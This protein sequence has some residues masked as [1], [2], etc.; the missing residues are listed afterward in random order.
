[1]EASAV[2]ARLI[3][4]IFV[5]KGLISDADLELALQEQEKTGLRLGEILVSSF[6]VSRL[7]L[8]G[9]LAEQW[10]AI[11]RASAHDRL[12]PTRTAAETDAGDMAAIE[13]EWRRPDEEIAPVEERR[14]IGEIFV[15]KGVIT[16]EQLQRALDEQRQTGA[17]LGEVLVAQETL[18]RLELA[19]ALAEQWSDLQKLR[20]PEPRPIRVAG[21]PDL[22]PA[23]VES[24]AAQLELTRM[25]EELRHAVAS[26]EQRV[27]GVAVAEP[28]AERLSAVETGLAGTT[29]GVDELRAAL[30]EIRERLDEIMSA[31]HPDK[32]VIDRIHR[33]IE[34][35]AQRIA[36]AEQLTRSNDRDAE[37]TADDEL[38]RRIV[39][40]EE[41]LTAEPDH[42]GVEELRARL[43]EHEEQL[44]RAS[45]VDYEELQQTE[46]RLAG[47]IESIAALEDLRPIVH[48][49][50]GRA[51]ALAG[52]GSMTELADLRS[53]LAAADERI[54][55]TEALAERLQRV[56]ESMRAAGS[57]A[58][59]Q[60]TLTQRVDELLDRVSSPTDDA[61]LADLRERMDAFDSRVAAAESAA[62]RELDETAE[63]LSAAIEAVATVERL[64]PVVAE[65]AGRVA[66]AADA[67]E[68]ADLRSSVGVLEG[69][70]AAAATMA[71]A[72]LEERVSLLAGSLE[73][74][75]SLGS[76]EPRLDELAVELRARL[77][78]VERGDP[79]VEA[80]LAA[81]EEARRRVAELAGRVAESPD[82]RVYQTIDELA[83]QVADL[84]GRLGEL[85]PRV[86]DAALRDD[87]H[88]SVSAVEGVVAELAG[89][90]A[91]AADAAELADLRSSV[92]VLEGRVAAAATMAHA[93]L[94]ERVSLLA[95][96]LEAVS[97]L[98]SLEPRLDELAVELRARLD[99]VERGDP[100]VEAALAAAEEARRRVAELAGRVA[101]SPD[102]RVYQTIDELA[103]QVADLRGR[104]GELAPRVADAALR[105]DVHASVS[106]VEEIVEGLRVE[107]EASVENAAGRASQESFAALART[108]E[109]MTERLAEVET[110]DPAERIDEL[111]ARVAALQPNLDV[112]GAL[113]AH[114]DE[115]RAVE[116]D[117]RDRI[118]AQGQQLE[119][120]DVEQFV[121][122]VAGLSERVDQHLAAADSGIVEQVRAEVLGI[123]ER[124][125]S[126]DL[127]IERVAT[128]GGQRL[129]EELDVAAAA[130]RSRL[131]EHERRLDCIRPDELGHRIDLLAQS[132]ADAA[133]REE[134]GHQIAGLDGRLEGL[135]AI[136]SVGRLGDELRSKSAD[137][138]RRLRD[139]EQRFEATRGVLDGLARVESL[140]EL[141]V[142]LRLQQARLDEQEQRV[143]R[144]ETHV[145]ELA[146]AASVDDLR[147][148]GAKAVKRMDDH[149]R[150]LA[151]A[152]TA[153][154]E[155]RARLEQAEELVARVERTEL[156]V[157]ELEDRGDGGLEER[158]D[159]LAADLQERVEKHE[160]RLD[161]HT[162]KL[163]DVRETS[164][165]STAELTARLE[166]RFDIVEQKA[167]SRSAEAAERLEAT[168]DRIDL[169]D[170]ALGDQAQRAAG[171]TTELHAALTQLDERVARE[172][173]A[174]E[175]R[176]Q[177]LVETR[178]ADTNA[179]IDPLASTDVVDAL[180]VRMEIMERH[181][182]DRLTRDAG[183]DAEGLKLAERVD[184]VAALV[185]EKT[186]AAAVAADAK[187]EAVVRAVDDELQGRRADLEQ[188]LF[189]LRSQI[190]D[191]AQLAEQQ[192]SASE[193]A[194]RDGLAALG[195]QLAE[196][197]S[198]YLRAG[199]LL[200]TSIE[201]LGGAI[202]ETDRRIA[203]RAENLPVATA[204]EAASHLAF[205]PTASGYRLVEVE[206]AAPAIGE[207][208]TLPGEELPLVAVRLGTS[209]LPLD[210]RPCVYLE[211]H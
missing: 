141:E 99:G 43:D 3:G 108:L 21:A 63:R 104:L 126:L 151:G 119:A 49:L 169:L 160:R 9:A 109:Q 98:G 115:L 81:A 156:R 79:R 206:G 5:D 92:G 136:D 161:K 181:L 204:S 53:A 201:R 150:K 130:L 170:A 197:E 193:H 153:E 122:Q 211:S 28:L 86:A 202:G 164:E 94:E 120:I 139:H 142:A 184:A 165:R 177:E 66:G 103:T 72:E 178:A 117:L 134:V 42:A 194:L 163:E 185:E 16:E 33:S 13:Q 168:S 85:A 75:S 210:L 7:D 84:R 188:S 18:T 93:E 32:A 17:R 65:L 25:T 171:S 195:A 205:A 52:A 146:T 2:S 95:G 116:A 113:A 23:A 140:E 51:Q 70:V 39:E 175:R 101:E 110:K 15:E 186:T 149:E 147:S 45:G 180:R 111:A 20:P 96:S 114:A 55:E 12:A 125:E 46:A 57:I 176:T 27:A 187:L 56:E 166:K 36:M 155:L 143:A 191:Q 200:R 47:A 183:R 144:T 157:E 82:A 190:V 73:A 37:R 89:R 26:L 208:V 179:R 97:S 54:A 128:E 133:S 105:D 198:A 78:G 87:V 121:R 31:E 67:A 129:R 48:D 124:V 172:A 35:L 159:T 30:G 107:L 62:R 100:R 199:E 138:E 40:L 29:A 209:P 135:A 192:A 137:L 60:A 167:A 59:Q 19:S 4:A 38:V 68:L 182:A 196:G 77:D 203:A 8:S 22:R 44:A 83:T 189:G 6:G 127:D 207:T 14:P 50:V 106:A 71:H 154:S 162:R 90:V 80:A 11:E 88:A 123:V 34:Q 148:A 91:G 152:L 64:E 158:L 69:R 76:L 61:P 41:R 74:V 112:E 173:K 145:A 10:T 102:A 118:A 58:A 24:S 1:M 131:D 174:L 132:L